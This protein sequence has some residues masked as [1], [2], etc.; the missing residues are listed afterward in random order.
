VTPKSRNA[1]LCS[2]VEA[3]LLEKWVCIGSLLPIGSL[4]SRQT[5]FSEIAESLSARESLKSLDGGRAKPS[6]S[7]IGQRGSTYPVASQQRLRERPT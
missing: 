6:G 1:R 2:F 3:R 4:F 7:K 5:L